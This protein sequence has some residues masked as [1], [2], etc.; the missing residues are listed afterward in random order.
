[1]ACANFGHQASFV[2]ALPDNEIATTALRKLG[3]WGVDTSHVLRTG[4]RIG[5]YYLEEGVYQRPSSVIYDRA[6][7]SMATVSPDAFDWDGDPQQCGLVSLHGH[8]ARAF[9]QRG[10]G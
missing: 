2:T 7:S 9:G 1:V 4:K 5:V 3:Y 8:H 10:G 6:D